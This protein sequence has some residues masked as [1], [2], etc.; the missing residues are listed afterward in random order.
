LAY[1]F[2]TNV[3]AFNSLGLDVDNEDFD[4]YGT[5]QI[6][7]LVEA[8][9]DMTQT[10]MNFIA[11]HE[12]GHSFGLD[13]IYDEEFIGLTIMYGYASG[14]DELIPELRPFDLY[15]LYYIYFNEEDQVE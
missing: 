9:E 4:T 11:L 13:D 8:M 6:T 2:V 10:E 1:D 15:N 7:F 12:M 14:Q 3:I 5:T